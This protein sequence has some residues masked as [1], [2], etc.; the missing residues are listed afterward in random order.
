MDW[1]V[2]EVTQINLHHSKGASAILARHQSKMH[3]AISLMQEPWVV[4]GCVRG[5]AACGKLFRAPTEQRSRAYIAVKGLEA[6]LLPELCSRDLAAVEVM[7][8]GRIG[9]TKR[10]VICSAYFP[11]GK[12]VPPP[13]LVRLVDFCQKEGLLVVGCDANAHHTIWGSTNMN[14]RGEKL[15]EYLITTDLEVLNRGNQPTFCTRVRREVLDLTLCSRRAMSEVTGWR[16]SNE[17]SLSDHRLIT[18]RLS[19]LKVEARKVRNPKRTD[20]L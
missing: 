11:H 3:T 10:L 7:A 17:P 12:E 16:V 4:H 8:T 14:E 18:F 13:E 6:C 1:S 2:I 9:G 19:D 20:L 5:V 15:L